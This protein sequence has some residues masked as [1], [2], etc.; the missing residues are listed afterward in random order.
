[1]TAFTIVTALLNLAIGF[2]LAVYLGAAPRFGTTEPSPLVRRLMRL[3][4]FRRRA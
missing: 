2:G 1:M 4:P 3:V